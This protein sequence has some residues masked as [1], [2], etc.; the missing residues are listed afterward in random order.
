MPARDKLSLTRIVPFDSHCAQG[1]LYIRI[2]GSDRD[3]SRKCVEILKQYPGRN[4]V[5]FV[6]S[7]LSKVVRSNA[8]NGCRPGAKLFTELSDL[9]GEDNIRLV[10]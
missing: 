3:I 6:L 4:E 9:C 1:R 5:F 2:A 10:R 7:D 8:V